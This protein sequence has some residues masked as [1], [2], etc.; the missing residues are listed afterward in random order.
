LRILAE[1]IDAGAD[2]NALGGDGAH[3]CIG[4]ATST[5]Q[6]PSNSFS[7]RGLISMSP[8]TGGEPRSTSPRA[9]AAPRSPNYCSNEERIR[10]PRPARGGRPSTS[11]P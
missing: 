7:T 5:I 8:I 6:W 10:M 11:H 1:L 3:R 9:A 2:V 4:P